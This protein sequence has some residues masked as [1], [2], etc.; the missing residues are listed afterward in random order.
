MTN[1]LRLLVIVLPSLLFPLF[2]KAQ[3]LGK[4]DLLAD[5]ITYQ[6]SVIPSVDWS[7][8]L[9]ITNSA[10]V[11]L[12]AETGTF[13][14]INLQDFTGSWELSTTIVSPPDAPQYDYFSFRLKIPLS[15]VD[16]VSGQEMYLF[17]VQNGQPCAIVSLFDN[18][19]DPF[20]PPNSMSINI[21][22]AFSVLGAGPGVNAYS[23]NMIPVAECDPPPPVFMN[24]MADVDAV[25][26]QGDLTNVTVT[27]IGG[28]EPYSVSWENIDSGDN[29]NGQ[30]L[31]Y[32]GTITFTDLGAGEYTFR[33]TD[34]N[35]LMVQEVLTITEPNPITF[36]LTSINADC[37]GTP[38]GQINIENL[39]GG[40]VAGDYNYAWSA[41]VNQTGSTV[42]D[43][44]PGLYSLTITDDNGCSAENQVEV[45]C[46]PP[47]VFISVIADVP[48]ILC[49]GGTA[50]LTVNAIQGE[51]PYQVS[52]EN[53]MNGDNGNGQILDYEGSITFSDF[54]AGNYNFT[55]T[56]NNDQVVTETV[57]VVEPEPI[58]FDLDPSRA[59]CEG[60][61]DGQIIIRNL[62]GGTISNDYNYD[63][64]P[65]VT[66]NDSIVTGLVPGIYMV[67]ITDDNGCSEESQVEVD[68]EFMLEPSP[69]ITDVT[70][71]GA[72]DGV[73]DLYSGG[74]SQPFN[75]NWS[76]NGYSGDESSAWGLSGGMYY[77]TITDNSGL[78][79]FSDSIIVN[80][81][82][83][84]TFE[85]ELTEPTCQN[86]TQAS[87]RI[88]KVFGALNGYQFSTNGAQYFDDP[89]FNLTPGSNQTIY[90]KDGNGCVGT[91]DI[92]VPVYD[93]PQI[94]MEE[95]VTINLGE[96]IPINAVVFPNDG[97]TLSWTPAETLS[98]DDCPEPIAKPLESTTYR[99]TAIDEA[100]CREEGSITIYVTKNRLVY[101]P[102]AF[103]PNNDG[104]NDYFTLF[105]GPGVTAVHS[106]RV[107][108]RWG[109]MVFEAADGYEPNA[110]PLGWN[111]RFNGQEMKRGVYIFSA[112]IEYEDGLKEVFAGEV[113][114]TR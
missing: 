45:E 21:G 8:P 78:C 23:D 34:N 3:L 108:N 39:E 61:P 26:C 72:D 76:G 95:D 66:Q 58:T 1:P 88:D 48:V 62:N 100:G 114:L 110:E 102:N 103:S 84:I 92:P 54:P 15:G 83:P 91:E 17:S 98:C 49:Y 94:F 70:C 25:P 99:L 6:V 32:E 55:L 73:I 90:V 89:E 11:T 112:L 56:D 75:F 96:E 47:P 64:S 57:T 10:Q 31:D 43:L 16:Y 27:A 28:E 41:V 53:T 67:T 74:G 111:G 60:A 86:P 104:T 9:S 51:Q 5:E 87:I 22:T 13:N 79:T 97:L 19:N 20:L 14:P 52:W 59:S 29:G 113:T 68:A 44:D 69:E 101:A 37:L 82:S 71:F 65:T 109:E 24:L 81:P 12:R 18:M 85:F 80:E 107:F 77:Y 106:L 2:S 40:T 46:N 36:A 35:G 50:N 93:A 7:S 38:N 30:I 33:I 63:W 4:I 105:T 42:T